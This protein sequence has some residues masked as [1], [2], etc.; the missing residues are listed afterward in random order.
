MWSDSGAP[1]QSKALKLLGERLGAD[2]CFY[3]LYDDERNVA[4]IEEDWTK[5]GVPSLRGEW[6]LT[7]HGASVV[8]IYLGSK[9]AVV[10]DVAEAALPKNLANLFLETGQRAYI[11]VPFFEQGRP[12]A[13]LT[14][15]MANEARDWS[16]DEVELV[17]AVAVQLRGALEAARAAQ[18]ER[19]ISHQL[20][21]A[22]QP[23]LPESAPGLTLANRYKPGLQEAGVGGD[24]YDVFSIAN[25][26]VA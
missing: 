13:A 2:R 11:A 17:E 3:V 25:G 10:R 22:L 20:Q 18:R 6:E 4:R 23:R 26:C 19:N 14:I 24:F 15:M 12:L 21:R 16:Q 8:D 7:E 5:E 1:P 9:T